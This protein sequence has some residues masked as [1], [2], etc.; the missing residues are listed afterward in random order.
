MRFSFSFIS[1]SILGWDWLCLASLLW[2]GYFTRVQ[3]EWCKLQILHHVFPGAKYFIFFKF[4]ML[5]NDIENE[6]FWNNFVQ[7]KISH[8]TRILQ[9]HFP[10]KKITD[11]AWLKTQVELHVLIKDF[12]RWKIVC[13]IAQ[14]CILQRNF[15]TE[16]F[17]IKTCNF[18]LGFQSCKMS[19][20]PLWKIIL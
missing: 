2:P 10:W 15:H 4:C 19:N 13:K 9:Y 5:E 7:V 8:F 14:K 20:F 17:L 11:F 6:V 18:I 16:K 1:A 3:N 12:A